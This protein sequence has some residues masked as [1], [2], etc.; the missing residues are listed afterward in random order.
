MT[1]AKCLHALS[2]DV[3]MVGVKIYGTQQ[4]EQVDCSAKDGALHT[5]HP[6]QIHPCVWGGMSKMRPNA[7]NRK[8][9]STPSLPGQWSLY[10]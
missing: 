10:S 4:L 8:C 9:I 3:S 7:P 5:V 6:H 1:K 2:V